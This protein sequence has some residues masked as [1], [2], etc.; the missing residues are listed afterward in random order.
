MDMAS[1]CFYF[2]VNYGLSGRYRIGDDSPADRPRSQVFR[3]MLSRFITLNQLVCVKTLSSELCTLF[4]QYWGL[5][6]IDSVK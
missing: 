6:E 5:I 1:R 4:E 2:L 3:R